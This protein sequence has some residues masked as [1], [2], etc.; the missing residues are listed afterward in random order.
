MDLKRGKRS[1]YH[2]LKA[3]V[4]NCLSQVPA[5]SIPM[6]IPYLIGTAKHPRRRASDR[7]LPGCAWACLACKHSYLLV[8]IALPQGRVRLPRPNRTDPAPPALR[9]GTGA[10][11]GKRGRHDHVLG[12]GRAGACAG[13]AAPESGEHHLCRGAP[14]AAAAAALAAPVPLRAAAV[15]SAHRPRTAGARAAAD[16]C[17]PAPRGRSRRLVATS[18]ARARTRTCPSGPARGV[19][20]LCGAMHLAD[21]RD[22]LALSVGVA[23]DPRPPAHLS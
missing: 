11:D 13:L 10:G 2:Q 22:P 9:L 15:S 17:V 21:M 7:A 8:D 19:H 12:R 5:L 6:C 18:R 14:R 3:A 23:L 1:G 20:G 4:F 16:W